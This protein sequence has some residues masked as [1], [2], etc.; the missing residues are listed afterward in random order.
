M[1]IYSHKTSQYTKCCHESSWEQQKGQ[2]RWADC[3]LLAVSQPPTNVLKIEHAICEP[4]PADMVKTEFQLTSLAGKG[5]SEDRYL[6][7]LR[8]MVAIKSYVW[9][10]GNNIAYTSRWTLWLPSCAR[11]IAVS[12][13]CRKL[14]SSF[15]SSP[16]A[17]L[18]MLQ[19]IAGESQKGLAMFSWQAGGAA[20]GTRLIEETSTKLR[21][22]S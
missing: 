6:H 4:N 7:D 13:Q 11:A 9:Y 12:I 3:R 19:T 20:Q 14:P 15:R 17:P 8:R 21:C 5:S 1:L 18:R 16:R 22:L 2:L 10:A